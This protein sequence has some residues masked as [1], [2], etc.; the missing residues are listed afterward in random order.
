MVVL[1]RATTTFIHYLT[2]LT[3]LYVAYTCIY[4]GPSAP[5]RRWGWATWLRLVLLGP[6]SLAT[7]PIAIVVGAPRPI[8]RPLTYGT[9]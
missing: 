5:V 8:R 4:L 6:S 9:R 3:L 2:F 1:I 7:R